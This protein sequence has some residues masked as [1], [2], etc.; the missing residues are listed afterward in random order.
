MKKQQLQKLLASE[1]MNV[2]NTKPVAEYL[3]YSKERNL[4]K[5]KK[6]ITPEEFQER[7]KE[8]DPS[9]SFCCN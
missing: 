7:L 2:I 9:K 3:K 1:Q 5:L 8:K 4:A 6:L